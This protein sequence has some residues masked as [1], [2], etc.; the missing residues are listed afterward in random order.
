MTEI[1]REKMQLAANHDRSVAA[2]RQALSRRGCA[3]I[4]SAVHQHGAADAV[5][6]RRSSP[7]EEDAR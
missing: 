5:P 3:R 6:Q 7:K 2:G 1:L 4:D